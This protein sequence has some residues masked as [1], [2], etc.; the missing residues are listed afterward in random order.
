MT[1]D[2]SAHVVM[3]TLHRSGVPAGVLQHY[4][5]VLEDPHLAGRG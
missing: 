4:S 1:G 3:E 5:Q 2:G